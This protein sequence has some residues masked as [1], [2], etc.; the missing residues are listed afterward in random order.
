MISIV[1]QHLNA[2]TPQHLNTSTPQYDRNLQPRPPGRPGPPPSHPSSSSPRLRPR[3]NPQL[4]TGLPRDRLT[5]LCASHIH[6][7]S[8]SPLP[9]SGGLALTISWKCSAHSPHGY[10]LVIISIRFFAS[11][12]CLGDGLSGYCAASVCRNTHVAVPRSSFVVVVRP[13]AFPFL[14][15]SPSPSPSPFRLGFGNRRRRAGSCV[16]CIADCCVVVVVVGCAGWVD[17]FV[18]SPNQRSSAILARASGLATTDDTDVTAS[19]HRRA[20]RRILSSP[21]SS[22]SVTSATRRRRSA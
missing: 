21:A 12:F 17:G 4:N 6:R 9:T 13:V 3:T 7:A 8:P 18:P 16:R 22:T 15:P 5:A 11:R 19:E 1:S 14:S 10:N 2:S 20:R